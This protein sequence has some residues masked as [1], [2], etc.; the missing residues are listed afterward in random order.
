MFNKPTVLV[1][2]AGASWEFGMPLGADLMTRVA[3]TVTLASNGQPNN[4]SFLQQ[5][6]SSLGNERAGTLYQLGS[7]LAAIVSAFK[8]MDEVLHFLSAE[9]DIVEL[10]KLAIAHE[11]MN[12]EFASRLYKAI[13]ANDPGLGDTNNT[14]AYSFLRLALSTSRRDELPKLFANLTVIDF[15]YDR[16]L[17]QYLYWALQRNL[18]IPPDIA[19]ECVNNLKFLNP[20]GSLGKL[21]WQSK[22][23]CMPFGTIQG[24]LAQVAS[25]IRTYTEEAQGPERLEISSAIE[26]AKV[27]IVIGFG[28]H[29]QNIK[30]VSAGGAFR[31]VA[32][33]MTVYGTGDP[34]H[35]TITARM[36]SA[37]LSEIAPQIYTGIGKT[38][39]AELGLSI[40][41]AAS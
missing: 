14:W 15:N 26:G 24:N 37:F 22:T 5:M 36:Q 21:E 6:Q 40:D 18:E 29:K 27:V 35:E 4:G 9:H 12:A 33:F 3:K 8:S 32:V 38:F 30:L 10:G 19:A 34:N 11:I 2:G 1:I 39:L 20:Y 13:A 25:R 31:P 41:L 7:Q 23:D 17:P 28:F 16:I